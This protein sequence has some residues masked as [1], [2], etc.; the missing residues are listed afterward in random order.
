VS[1]PR[2]DILKNWHKIGR[3]NGYE[4]TVGRLCDL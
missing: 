2:E 3:S 1:G 4:T